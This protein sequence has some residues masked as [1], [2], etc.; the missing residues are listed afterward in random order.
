[1]R[2]LQSQRNSYTRQTAWPRGDCNTEDCNPDHPHPIGHPVK[3]SALLSDDGRVEAGH[4]PASARVDRQSSYRQ[5]SQAADRHTRASSRSSDVPGFVT[6][7]VAT[8]YGTPAVLRAQGVVGEGR[9]HPGAGELE[10]RRLRPT[11]PVIAAVNNEDIYLYLFKL[12][13]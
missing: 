3:V 4:P 1:M 13:P 5:P 11:I 12:T 2:A 8:G 10:S 6:R 7:K 9:F